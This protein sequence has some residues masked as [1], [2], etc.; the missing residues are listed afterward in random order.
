MKIKA[1]VVRQKGGPFLLEDLDLDEP[2]E[3]EVLVRIAGAGLCHTDLAARDQHLPS[4]LPIVLGHE[5]SG[6]VE[7]VGRS[8][9]RVSPGDHVV[10]S[11]LSCGICPLCRKG[12]ENYCVNTGL[13]NFGGIRPDGSTT[14]RNN[15]EP[16]HGS[17]FSQSSF[18]SFA[19]ASER[20]TVKAPKDVAIEILGP[21]GCGIQTGAGGVINSLRPEAGSSLA[22]FGTGGVGM[23]AILAAVV[24]GCATIIAVDV[25]ESR[26]RLA[27]QFGATHAI[28]PNLQDPVQM[29]R[30]ITGLGVDYVLDTTGIPSLIAQA[31]ESTTLAG[32][33]GLIGL[34]SAD[35]QISL[36][37][38]TILRGR[39][40]FG[41]IEGDAV[42]DLFIPR[43]IE[44][45][46]EGRFP[47]DKMITFYDLEKINEAALDS[48]N[49]K[50]LKAVLRP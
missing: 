16:V 17:F 43:L 5:G 28:D 47:F 34:T 49:G 30:E 50:T 44:L 3:D 15:G 31:V 18:A 25:K 42:P 7:K 27:R 12:K 29:I 26:L 38:G 6:I 39:C 10:L 19:L 20:N 8:V 46:K 2:R 41:I 11:Y 23:G 36:A 9:K 13:L 48:E 1:A 21:L 37:V 40:V 32:K 33:C 22:V 14:L 24:S 4:P 35:A 45:Y